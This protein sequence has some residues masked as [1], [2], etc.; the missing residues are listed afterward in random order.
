M[1]ESKGGYDTTRRHTP[2]PP[3]PWLLIDL[4]PAF[5]MPDGV[6]E[7]VDREIRQLTLRAFRQ[8]TRSDEWIYA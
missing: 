4:D 5:V 8:C 6:P 7:R 2:H 1:L 3:S